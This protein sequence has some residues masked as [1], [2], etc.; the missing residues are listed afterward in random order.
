MTP[1]EWCI[2]GLLVWISTHAVRVNNRPTA[3]P[4]QPASFGASMGALLGARVGEFIQRQVAANT[5]SALAARRAGERAAIIALIKETMAEHAAELK[6]RA[7]GTGRFRKETD[8][9]KLG[10][11]RDPGRQ[12]TPR[13]QEVA[14]SDDGRGAGL[15]SASR[16]DQR[17]ETA[18]EEH[19]AIPAVDV[20]VVVDDPELLRSATSAPDGQPP[21]TESKA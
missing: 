19:A 7:D 4:P 18:A 17:P 13:I 21:I 14:P 1:F 6:E 12:D 9:I 20:A 11:G 2:L 16:P 8:D 10:V 3:P 15:V 5:G